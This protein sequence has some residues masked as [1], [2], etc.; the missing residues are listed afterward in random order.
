MGSIRAACVTDLRV[1]RLKTIFLANA[2]D[3][4]MRIHAAGTVGRDGRTSCE[5]LMRSIVVVKKVRLEIRVIEM[6][7][8]LKQF[9][10]Y[11][12]AEYIK[13]SALLPIL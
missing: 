3:V 8:H 1:P 4:S 11:T 7:H 2:E 10:I 9:T 5:E 6:Q 12:T 13:Y